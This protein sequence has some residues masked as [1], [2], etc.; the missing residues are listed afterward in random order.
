MENYEIRWHGRGGQG[1]VTAAKLLAQAAM[2]KGYHIQALPSFEPSK[3]GDPVEAY[4]RLSKKPVR[5]RHP[6]ENPDFVIVLDPT[7]LKTVDPTKGLKKNGFLLVNTEKSPEEIRKI[8]SIPDEIQVKTLDATR[9]SLEE[10]D[11]N[12]ARPNTALPGA[13]VKLAGIVDLEGVERA[14]H[15]AFKGPRAAELVEKNLK[16]V[17]RG[18]EEVR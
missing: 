11:P 13:F 10:V 9:I 3:Q 1:A 4:N 6:V 2:E 5:V 16:A 8:F 12:K 14:L 18:Y 15:K 7:L 17:K